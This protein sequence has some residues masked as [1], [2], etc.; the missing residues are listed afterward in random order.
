VEPR[1]EPKI[2]V[3]IC[4]CGSNIAGTVDVEAVTEFARQLPSVTV[5][6]N[7]KYMCSDPGQDLIRQDIKELG[8]NRVV[9]ASCS[10]LMHE[11]TYRRVC[12]ESGLNPYL[13]EMANIREHCSWVTEDRE[14]AT[15]KAKALVSAA[16]RRVYYQEPLET[17]EVPVNPNTLVVGGGISGIQAALEIA[18]SKHK[19]YLVEREP[20][21]GGHMSQLDKTFPTL[22]CSACILTPKMSL[23]GAHP[24]IELMSYSEV[25]EVSGYVGNFKAK[26]KKKARYVDVDKCTGCSECANVCPV[27]VPNEFDLGLGQRK[28]I[29]R[30]FP[31]AVPN[32]F[33][34]DKRGYPPCRVACP[35]GVNAQ[36]Y[37]ALIS[38]GKFKEALE[39]LRQT[40]P[41]AGVCGRVCTHP[42]ESECE[43]GKVDEPVS[44]RSLKRFMADYELKVGREK[45]TPIERTKEDKVAIIG[46]GPA[47]LGCAYDLIREGYPVTVFEAAS[48]AGGLLRWGIPEYRL[49]EKV[50]DN[51]IS[52]VKEMGVEIKTNTPVN[53]LEEIFNQ[54]YQ[55]IFLATGAGVSQKMG[56]PGEDTKGV[57]HAL[58]FLKKANSGVKVD[59]GERVAVIGGGN[60]AV[61]AARV[62]KRLGTKEVSIVYRRSRAEMPA[63]STEVDEAEREGVKLHILA[64]PVKVIAKN[65]KVTS[66][67]CIK[68]ELG[69]PD[70]SGRRRPVPVEGSEF[71]MD[72]DSVI[73]AIGQGVDKE[74]LPK[75]LEYTTWGTLVVDPVTLQTNIEGVFAGGDVVSGPADVI[76][77]VAAGKEAATS[78]DRYL[79]G[80]DLKE[81]RPAPVKR[82]KEVSKEGVEAKARQ[83]MPTLAPGKREGFTEVELGFD[84]K[85]AIEEAKRCLNCG[86]CSECMECVKACQ[87]GAINHD[88]K[89]ETVEV[90]VGNIIV[91]TGYDAFDPTPLYQY[92]YKRLDN[93]ITSLEF[94]RMINASG[95]TAGEV[96]LKDGSPPK[97]VGII[98]CVGSR[99][100]KYHE[101]CSQVCCMYSMKFGHLIREHVPGA[102][103]TEF[104][105]DL[106]CVGKAFEEFYNRVLDEG[107]TFIRGRPAE[108]TDIAESPEEEGKLIIIGEDTLIGRQ[109]RVPVDM[110]VLSTALEPRADAEEVARMFSIGRSADG[111]FLEK[112]PKLDPVATMS[113]GIYVVGCCQSPKD[114]PHSVAQASAAAARAL[115]M[116]S[117]GSIEIEAATSVV[118]EELCS[119]CKICSDL[120]PFNAISFDEEKKVSRINE[121]LCKGCGVCVAACPSGAITGRHF[122]GDELMAEI[123][124]ALV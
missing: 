116:I 75:E 68:M 1:E 18:D 37:V 32:V 108:V 111:F 65:D 123:E 63:V 105:I 57:I 90:D 44:I 118:N 73:M 33:A 115:A 7:Y 17:K 19:V 67:Q 81:G 27:E 79:R 59:L 103:V 11:R 36:G 95:P 39:V 89:E 110:V 35:A 100:E 58:D 94:E 61:D 104:Y 69:E 38:Q 112:H 41:F 46:S 120:C 5:A 117:A 83:A 106:R 109:R 12:Q 113:D 45:A 30:P 48:Q 96:F 71:N 40:M 84:E 107:T 9:V 55:A 2:G 62:A 102:Q 28:A 86:V 53:N 50:L 52:Y 56:I 74:A 99:D 70:A 25:A 64:A 6:R 66:I 119:G 15:E 60:A 54:G 87:V 13:F 80:V 98:H 82:V 101:Y 31:Q 97:T 4:H 34:I 78:I 114:I 76:A 51:E 92:G 21:I 77:A 91:A 20:S 22:D 24:Y 43:R 14:A 10:P 72:V 88:M 49:P 121:T 29:Y 93:V 26:I 85:A 23:V 42:C 8:I 16:V 3:Y 124:G 47:G 122:T